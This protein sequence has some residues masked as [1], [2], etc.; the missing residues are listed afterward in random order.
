MKIQLEALQIAPQHSF[1]VM[2]NPRMSD[3]FFWHSHPEYELVYIIGTDGTRHVGS[4]ISKYY[5]SDLVLIGSH[6]PHLNF[7]YGAK[8]VYEK[9]V[10]HF[11]KEVIENFIANIPELEK[12]NSVFEAANKCIAFGKNT[13]KQVGERLLKLAE[14]AH[15]EQLL[16]LL[17]ILNTI[18]Q[19]TDITYLHNKPFENQYNKKEQ[20]RL[21][22][23]YKFIDENYK[24]KIDIDEVA[25][26]TNLSNAAFCRYFKKMTRLTFIEFLNHYRINQAKKLLL[27][28]KNVT[29]SCYETGFESLSYF[30][31]TFKKITS[32][33][34]ITFKKRHT[35]QAIEMT[36]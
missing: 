27:I 25:Q 8:N 2:V 24:R 23:I 5:G 29:E 16:E 33:N 20:E 30:N 31:R 19:T 11:R 35:N 6:I 17:N 1:K 22:K 34:P 18:A 10:V 28:D 4:H 32:E 3:F 9:I 36:N 14:L 21:Q 13:Q 12:V 7:D 15:F 26:L